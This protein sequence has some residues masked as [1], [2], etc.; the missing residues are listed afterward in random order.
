M[1]LSEDYKLIGGITSEVYEKSVME[2]FFHE[3]RFKVTYNFNHK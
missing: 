1:H 2:D 3:N